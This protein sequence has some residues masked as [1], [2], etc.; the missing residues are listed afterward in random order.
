MPFLAAA[1]NVVG[2]I[3]LAHAIFSTHEH[4]SLHPLSPLPRDIP[5][6]LLLSL[7][8]LTTGIVL[9]SP[10]L[11]PIQWSHWAGK[12]SRE[13]PSRE[14]YVTREGE[15]VLGDVDPYAYLGLEAGRE[16]RRGF[17]GPREAR[18]RFLGWVKEGGEGVRLRLG[19]LWCEYT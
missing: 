9:S 10:P 15:E 14:G 3:F 16:G 11:K 6:E 19:S 1:L 13:G 12:I 18:E 8:L 5:L 17:W 7:A 2:A 4:T